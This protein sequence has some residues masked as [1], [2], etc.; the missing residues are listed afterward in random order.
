MHG[1]LRLN[2]RKI[3]ACEQKKSNRFKIKVGTLVSNCKPESA[4]RLVVAYK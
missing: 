4:Y 2:K 3:T 1:S